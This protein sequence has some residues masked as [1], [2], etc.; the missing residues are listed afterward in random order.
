MPHH[1]SHGNPEHLGEYVEKLD[2]PERK[3]WQKPDEVIAALRIAR[4]ATACEIGGGS[5]YFSLRLARAVGEQGHVFAVDASPP[6]L[7]LLRDRVARDGIRNLTPVLAAGDDPLLPPASCDTALMVNTFHHF[8]DKT[9]YLRRLSRALRPGA[10]VAIIDFYEHELP[11]GPPPEQ[12]VSKAA[13][14]DHARAAGFVLERE[15]GFL[16][17][18]Y[19]LVFHRGD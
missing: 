17:Y 5:G 9:G 1:D 4:G 8:H 18:Q 15:E 19:F 13:A 16:P 2:S 7:S 14:L 10:R 6:L 3:Q 11:T 12:K